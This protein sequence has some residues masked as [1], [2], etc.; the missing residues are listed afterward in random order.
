MSPTI[1][2]SWDLGT[3]W[4]LLA[5]VILL[6]AA[7]LA[8]TTWET[9][10]TGEM[11]EEGM[12][13]LETAPGDGYVVAGHTMS[14]GPGSPNTTNPLLVR[15]D[16]DGTVLWY[17]VYGNDRIEYGYDVAKDPESGGYLIC[18]QRVV[19]GINED[20]LLIK[21]DEEGNEVWSRTYGGS[22]YDAALAMTRSRSG[23]YLVAGATTA[24]MYALS[25]AWLF[26][27]GADGDTLWTRSYGGPSSETARSLVELPDGNIVL[28]VAGPAFTLIKTD[29]HGSVI[30]E[31][32]HMEANWLWPRRIVPTSPDKGFAVIGTAVDANGRSDV[33]LLKLDHTGELQWTQQYNYGLSDVGESFQQAADGGFVICGMTNS[34][35]AGQQDLLLIRTDELGNVKWT[36]THGAGHERYADMGYGVALTADGGIVATGITSS[37]GPGTNVYILKTDRDGRLNALGMTAAAPG[38][39]NLPPPAV[40]QP[41]PFSG[42]TSAPGRSDERFVVYDV[43]GRLAGTYRGDRIG[44]DL[45]PGVYFVRRSGETKPT[46]R[47]VKSQ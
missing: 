10:F 31:R 6:P 37:V 11:N 41:N 8:E 17:Q 43:A 24:N 13:I 26:K 14:W 7:A 9:V 20:G 15:L 46:W 32:S 19:G 21:T 45:V 4:I 29:A 34:M 22:G 3:F 5:G 40:L 30:W 23:G 36:R 38:P 12:A 39:G 16:A 35:G 27:V 33:V 1:I 18:A 44:S 47:V 42:W 28:C 25:D 2:R